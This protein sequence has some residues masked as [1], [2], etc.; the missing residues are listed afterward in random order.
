MDMEEFIFKS[1]SIATTSTSHSYCH[2]DARKITWTILFS[3]S[4]RINSL[5]RKKFQSASTYC[6][7]KNDYY[8]YF[9]DEKHMEYLMN[10]RKFTYNG[11]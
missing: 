10:M 6:A 2:Q 5:I 7:G 11:Y 4:S 9:R 3:P 1:K 8:F